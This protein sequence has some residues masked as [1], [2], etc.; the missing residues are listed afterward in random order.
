MHAKCICRI[1][2]PANWTV[3]RISGRDRVVRCA[4]CRQIWHTTG[5][6]AE[7]LT[8]EIVSPYQWRQY[9]HSRDYHREPPVIGEP[10]SYLDPEF[11]SVFDNPKK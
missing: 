10:G 3:I 1:P 8:E 11:K 6:Y 5:D 2:D 9:I 4:A 7:E